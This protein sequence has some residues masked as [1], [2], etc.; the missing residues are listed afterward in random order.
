MDNEK[1]ISKQFIGKRVVSKTGKVFGDVANLL[2]DTKTGEVLQIALK[3]T[4]GYCEGLELEKSK[5]GEVL[6]P[7]GAVVAMQ[8]FLVVAEEDII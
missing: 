5:D 4:T 1:R 3:N 6:L 8:D 2:F 7:Y